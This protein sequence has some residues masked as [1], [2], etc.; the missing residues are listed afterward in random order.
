MPGN[1]KKTIE[2]LRSQ[3]NDYAY[4][5][6]VLDEP[7]TS[8]VQYDNLYQQLLELESRYPQYISPDSPTQRVGDKPLDGFKQI[9]HEVPM[10][11]LGN[12]F[13]ESELIEFDQ[14]LI[15]LAQV[16]E[17]E[18]SAEPK[19]DGLAV[20]I[21]YEKGNLLQAAT[22]GD[23][24]IG[25]DITANVKTIKAIPLVLRG[26][27][28]P[29]KLEVRGEVIMTRSGFDEYNRQAELLGEKIFANPRNAAAGSLRQ[30][31]P[32]KTAK[33]P[34]MFYAYSLGVVSQELHFKTH[35][36]TLNWVKSLGIPVNNLNQKV[37]GAK[38]CQQFYHMIGE[39]RPTLNYD[40]DGVVYKV[41]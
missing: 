19:L 25:E 34:L 29:E 41:N 23:G 24:S 35:I 3:L 7:V 18:Y 26:N 17:I 10:L 30:L 36:E 1:I 13:S 20:S 28:I 5:Y 37:L 14:R 6:Y 38:G 2:E 9:K 39:K 8:D 21:V 40:I 15:E 11:S 4:Q 22:R 27:N 16:G 12:V 32:R 31:D 33:R